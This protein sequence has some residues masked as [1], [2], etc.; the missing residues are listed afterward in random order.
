MLLR[1]PTLPH[2]QDNYTLYVEPRLSPNAGGMKKN[3]TRNGKSRSGS[4]TGG[5]SGAISAALWLVGLWHNLQTGDGLIG[6][7]DRIVERSIIL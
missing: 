4:Y 2:T 6:G 3:K 5:T 7:M 1:F